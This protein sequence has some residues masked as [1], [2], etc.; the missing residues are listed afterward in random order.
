MQDFTIRRGTP[1]DLQA[2]L[3]LITELAIFE[4]APNEVSNTTEKMLEDG[5]GQNPVFG[6]FVAQKADKIVGL[7][8]FYTRYSTWKGRCLYLEDIIVTE[9]E[10]GNSI[11]KKLMDAVVQEAIDRKDALMMW[12]VLDWNTPAIDFYK[13]YGARL[14]PEWINCKLDAQALQKWQFSE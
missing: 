4:K 5:F 9:S 10:R 14:E 6:F 1:D 7:A 2:A 12:Q 8:L 3:A 11:G 13:K